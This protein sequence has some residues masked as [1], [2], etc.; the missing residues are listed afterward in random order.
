MKHLSVELIKYAMIFII[1][2]YAYYSF[3]SHRL[4]DK[5]KQDLVC[6]KM[7]VL[8]FLIHLLGYGAIY[9]QTNNKQIITLYIIEL[10]LILFVTTIYKWIYPTIS[11]VLLNNILMLIVVGLI[12][13][14]RLSVDN[15][16][17]HLFMITISFVIS[18]VVPNIIEMQGWIKKLGAFYGIVGIILLLIV[19]F[20]GITVY[21]ATNWLEIKGFVFQ[22]SEFVKILYVLSI[23][24]L[25]ADKIDYKRI[26]LTSIMAALS[27]L[28]LVFEKDLGGALI[29]YVTYIFMLYFATNK[30]LYL[31]AG[32]LGGSGASYVAYKMFSHVRVRVMAWQNP[33]GLIDKEGYQVSQSLFAIGTGGWFGMGINK[34]MPNTIP[35]VDSDFIFSAIS[36]EFGALFAISLILIYI[37]TFLIMVIISFKIKDKFYR[38]LALGFSVMITFQVFLSIGGVTKF[39]PSTGVTLPLISYGGS[40]IISSIVMIMIIQGIYMRSD[41]KLND[42]SEAFLEEE[43]KQNKSTFR[44]IYIFLGLF[45]IMIGYL[46]NFLLFKRDEF[47]N[48]TYNART[49]ILEERIVRGDI[50]TSDRELVATTIINQDDSEYRLYP[51]N[52]LFAHSVGRIS[53]GKSGI[54]ESEN[55]RLLTSRMNSVENLFNELMGKKNKG[56]TIVTT[57][58]SN[59]QKVAYNALGSDRGTVIVLEVK[60]GRIL[61]MVSK[62]DYNPNEIDKIW[63]SIK[64]DTDNSVLI[65]RGTQGKYPPG[66]TYKLITALEFI[67]ENPSYVEYKYNCTGSITKGNMTIH[68]YNNNVHGEIN[69]KEAMAK[70]CNTFFAEIATK[71]DL[72]SLYTLNEELYFNKSLPINM[73]AN[74]SVYSLKK[75]SSSIDEIMQTSI[76]QGKTLVTP[77]HNAMIMSAVANNGVI[78]KPYIVEQI[79]EADGS[80]IKTTKTKEIAT[81]ISRTEAAILSNLLNEVVTSGTGKALN[82]LKVK[83][84]GKTGS[85][86]QTDKKAHAWFVGFAPFE[87]PEIVIAVLVENKGTGSAYAVPIAKEVIKY[88]FSEK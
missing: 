73:Q 55:I 17:K 32:L 20:Y 31:F 28:I 59:L 19:Y 9:L 23:A 54:E 70:S 64:D 51:Y 67:R 75:E 37:N 16:T 2:I 15:V 34:G 68:C 8:I 79:E 21:G 29:F 82:D 11:K 40:S 22:P 38:L 77:L 12:M 42:N 63:D 83:V 69:L 13:Q 44:V 72:D 60:T 87:S 53:K 84:A 62:P 36:E 5:N 76:G 61:T 49:N 47:I 30:S 86:E 41:S 24:A 25:F 80:I 66:S 81:P 39:I 6:F 48:N 4:K 14:L 26:V 88:Y 33:L 56:N 27:V 18:L 52:N 35:V 10:I 50:I 45:I 43:K 78:M 3:F 74:D 71:F 57:L 85:A 7:S 46:T 1:A 65:N 58:D